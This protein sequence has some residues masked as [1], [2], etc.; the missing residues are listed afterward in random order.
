MSP[1]LQPRSLSLRTILVLTISTLTLLIALLSLR[2]LYDEWR[3]WNKI[4]NLKQAVLVSQQFFNAIEQLSRERE[5][6]VALLY[7]PHPDID[8]NL[9]P[10][11][12][13]SRQAADAGINYILTS[14][15]H[16]TLTVDANILHDFE[17]EREKLLTIRK[18]TDQALALA[19]EKRDPV[20]AKEW[21]DTS[22][23]AIGTTYSLWID[24]T[25][26]F[27]EIDAIVTQRL[28]FQHFLGLIIRYSG[29][30]HAVIGSLIVAD[31]PATP[32]DQAQLLRWRGVIEQGWEMCARLSERSKLAPEITPYLKDAQS[33]YLSV[34][35]MV[36]DLFYVPGVM[37][38]HYPITI[39]QWL[40]VAGSSNDSLNALKNAALLQTQHYV[41]GLEHAA[42]RSMQLHLF[43]LLI[44][45]GLCSYSFWVV[46][47]RVIGPIQHMA[48]ALLDTAAGKSVT[49]MPFVTGKNDEVSKLAEVL[50]T[51]QKHVE[52]RSL[53]AAIVEFSDDAIISKR[54]D[55]IITS[56]N[57]GAERMFGY[58]VEEAVGQHINLIIPA[59]RRQEE[60]TLI[61]KLLA[62][63]SVVHFE[64][65]RRTK[66]G[67]LI[68]ISL[69]VSPIID[70]DGNIIGASKIARN[71]SD[72]KAAEHKL[73]RY[74]FDLERS[75]KELDDFAYIASHDLKE[76]LR[77][78]HNHSRFLL[79]DNEGKLEKDS[80][81]RL[82]RLL[83]LTQRMEKLVN[84]LLY[85][86]RLGRQELAIQP[87][88]LNE[89]VHD[90]KVMID[91]FLQERHATI[92]VPETLPTLVGDKVRLTEALRN[93]ITN[94][95]KYNNKDEKIVEIG[96]HETERDPN[97]NLEKNVLY[98]KDNGVGIAPEFHEVIFKIFKRLQNVKEG[99]EGTGVGLTFVKKIIE[100]HNGKI[101]LESRVGEGT[102]F[103]FNIGE[104]SHD[105]NPQ[106]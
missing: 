1:A 64:T 37:T 16:T 55:G 88:D 35:E 104:Y 13:Q 34:Y 80:V 85:F 28:M 21:F 26:S 9:L 20:F 52:A 14:F 72:R 12:Q 46:N 15:S 6:T 83:Y 102:I 74:M 79:E 95:I 36:E 59:D 106:T 29:R 5:I 60:K 47:R 96:F 41:E 30:E 38:A 51:L 22:T 97:G 48:N 39:D 61:A 89:V 50:A 66:E 73:Q 27:T 43:I 11:L 31:R 98:V 24:Y 63:H 103:Y 67:T 70:G 45:L 57:A 94:A 8:R 17:Q 19:S 7:S 32:E 101:W 68:D 25:R 87:T 86:S 40:E 58:T 44:G 23:Q 93:L 75:N 42:E 82:H 105:T 81:D 49:L 54:I 65:A 69:T 91:V 92:L 100:R 33:H 53:L 90:I 71:I 4:Q 99:E 62:G 18:Q 10:Q 78:I 56:W 3:Q 2:G 84:D 76:P 77:G